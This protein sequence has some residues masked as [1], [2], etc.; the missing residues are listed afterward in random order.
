MQRVMQVFLKSSCRLN[1]YNLDFNQAILC[2][3]S[4]KC[5]PSLNLF[6]PSVAFHME[7]SHSICIASQMTSFHMKY[8]TGLACVNSL[9]LNYF[10]QGVILLNVD[11]DTNRL[12]ESEQTSLN[13]LMNPGHV[14]LN[15]FN[16]SYCFI[17]LSRVIICVFSMKLYSFRPS[18]VY[19]LRS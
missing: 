1:F 2:G 8:N 9:I 19:F 3:R 15:E 13:R 5:S 6:Q 4:F 10:F 11:R 18:C 12:T 17:I 16:S 7:T 14:S